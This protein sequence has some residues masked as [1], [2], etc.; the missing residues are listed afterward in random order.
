MA[1]SQMS[2]GWCILIRRSCIPIC[3][4]T[5]LPDLGGVLVRS[6]RFFYELGCVVGC[7]RLTQSGGRGSIIGV[8]RTH[9]Q[10]DHRN[11]S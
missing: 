7:V 3:Q 10:A 2:A 5:A 11:G 8:R 1:H 6:L 4:T 9:V